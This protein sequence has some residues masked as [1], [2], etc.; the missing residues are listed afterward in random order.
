MIHLVDTRRLELLLELSRLGSMREVGEAIRSGVDELHRKR[1]PGDRGRARTRSRGLF[2]F[3]DAE[4][5][6]SRGSP[7]SDSMRPD[8]ARVLRMASVSPGPRSRIAEHGGAHSAQ[9]GAEG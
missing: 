4:A 6:G 9:F 5:H 7:R 1:R 2:S 8:G 3:P